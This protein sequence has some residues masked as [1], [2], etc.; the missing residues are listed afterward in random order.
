MKFK[1]LERKLMT[2][3]EVEEEFDVKADT[4]RNYIFKAKVIPKDAY[5]KKG[6][7]FLLS[8]EWV[9]KFYKDKKR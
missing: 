2:L 6:K 1:D 3:Q 7:T 5:F 4:L 9:E 8:R